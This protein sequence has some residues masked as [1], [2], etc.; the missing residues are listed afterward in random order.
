MSS[1]PLT[2]IEKSLLRKGLNFAIAPT[3]VPTLEII[4][5]VESISSLIDQIEAEEFRWKIREQL[6]RQP[7]PTSNISNEERRALNGLRRDNTIKIS[8]ADKGN[9]TVVMDTDLYE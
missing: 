6:D 9:A 7:V 2:D 1:R 4:T 5:A 3:L 8:P